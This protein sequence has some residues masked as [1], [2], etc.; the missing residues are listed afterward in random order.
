MAKDY[1]NYHRDESYKESEALFE[2][3]FLTRVGIVE[4]FISKLGKVLDIGTSTGVMLAIFKRKGWEVWGVEPSKSGDVA[5]KRGFK[6]LRTTFEKA[7]LPKNYF[8]LVVMNHVLEH[9]D[10]PVEVLERVGKLL[11]RNGIVLVDVPNAGG[12]GARIMGKRWRY[13]LSKEHKH[14]FTKESLFKVFK[15]AGFEVIYF[16][17]RTGICEYKKP[18]LELWRSLAGFKKRFFTDLLTAPYALL[19]TLF[20]MGDSMSLVGRKK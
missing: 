20:N 7:K 16:E 10:K 8:D 15:K 19:A 14:Q 3:I 11:R 6:V 9:M 1:S 4:K 17:S 5:K 12:L 18:F 2:N 13:R